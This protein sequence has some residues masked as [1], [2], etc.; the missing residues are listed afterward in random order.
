MGGGPL[1]KTKAKIAELCMEIHPLFLHPVRSLGWAIAPSSALLCQL[2]AQAMPLEP[3]HLLA[4]NQ[5]HQS[6]PHPSGR[7]ESSSPLAQTLDADRLDVDSEIL[8]NSPVLQRWLDTPPDLMDDIRHD[9]AFRTRVRV[10][11]AQVDDVSGFQLGVE[12]FFLGDTGLTLNADYHSADGSDDESWGVN[13]R[14]Y[15]LPL[16]SRVNISPVVGY[17]ELAT[18]DD[19]TNGAELGLRLLLVPSRPGAS[20]LSVSHTWV[21][22]GSDRQEASLTTFTAGYALTPHLRVSSDIQIQV[23][24]DRQDTRFGLG[25]EWML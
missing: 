21:N 25:L 4:S 1:I 22:P 14:Y 15:T 20:D 10:G 16:G 12:D 2:H 5:L 8:E 6:W 11:Y 23:T 19:H 13:L 7:S 24:G 17:R 3:S 9:P 18:P